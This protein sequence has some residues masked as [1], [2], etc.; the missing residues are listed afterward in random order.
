[1]RVLGISGS[2]RPGKTTDRLVQAVLDAVGCETEFVSLAGKKI[3]PCAACLACVRDNVCKIKDDMV[4]L[5]AKILA[6]D[7]LVIGAPNY[8]SALNALSHCFLERLC[9]FRHRD[10]RLLAGKYVVV[11]GTGGMEPAVPAA[12]IERM[13]PYYQMRHLGSV[14]ARGAASCFTCGCGETCGAGAVRMMHGPGVVIRAEIIPDLDR[15]PDKIAAARALGKKMAAA[16][17]G[18]G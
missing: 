1:M 12:M 8:F 3:A 16:L 4:P 11:V 10:C 18:D 17:Q 15:Q 13:L 9:Q 7:G 5:R 6:A 14:T 2:P